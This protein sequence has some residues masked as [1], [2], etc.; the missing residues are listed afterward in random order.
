MGWPS[1]DL[2]KVFDDNE[3]EDH[4]IGNI[5]H[6]IKQHTRTRKVLL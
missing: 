5:I 2:Q 4:K 1:S 6:T 3:I